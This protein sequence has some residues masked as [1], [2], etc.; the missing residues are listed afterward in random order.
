MYLKKAVMVV[1]GIL[2]A[3]L[4][5]PVGGITTLGHPQNTVILEL[6]RT[7]QRHGVIYSS[8]HLTDG[9]LDFECAAIENVKYAIPLGS[10]KTSLQWSD[11]FQRQTPHLEVLNR[12]YIEIHPSKNALGLRG[13]IGVSLQDF[14]TLTQ[15]LPS[16]ADFRVVVSS[17]V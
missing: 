10:Y 12:T 8:L 4:L 3:V 13:C 16:H 7:S 9:D 17:E 1:S 2:S 11:K 15:L 14:E 5:N 6:H